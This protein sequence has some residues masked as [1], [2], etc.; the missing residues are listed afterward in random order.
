M[1]QQAPFVDPHS[2]KS[3]S[4]K[5]LIVT[6]WH[7]RHLIIRLTYRDVVSRYRGSLLGLAWSLINPILMLLVYTYVFSEVFQA[8]W[9]SDILESKSRF[10]VTV[11]V[12][13]IILG[14]FSEVVN[15]APNLIL[16]NISYVKNMVF[17]IEVLPVVTMA[18]ALFNSFTCLLVLLASMLFFFDGLHWTVLFAPLIFLPLFVL[19]LGISLILTSLGVFLRDIGQVVTLA[20]TLLMFISPIFYP[21]SA[22]PER[23]QTVILLNPLTFIIEQSRSVIILGHYPNWSGLLIYLVNAI[24]FAWLGYYW[25]QKT[26]KGFADVL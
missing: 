18:S 1:K 9:G 24:L 10:A 12:G 15:R 5:N 16:Q 6:L 17:P 22:V 7:Q 26:R 3:T 20:T 2:G 13:M 4:L 8:K 11:F 19:L 14:F 23:F 25:F 21:I